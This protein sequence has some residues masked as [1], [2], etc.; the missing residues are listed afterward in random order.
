MSRKPNFINRSFKRQIFFLMLIVTLF[1]VIGGGIA[2][3]QGFQSRIRYDYQNQDEQQNESINEKLINA[4]KLSETTIEA[5]QNNETLIGAFSALGRDD[6]EI[7]TQLYDN[8]SLVRQFATV[9]LYANGRCIY[10]TNQSGNSEALP[11][12]YSILREAK[13]QDGKTVYSIDPNN[14]KDEGGTLLIARQVTNSYINGV[15]VIRITQG[16]ISNLLS[17]QI[18]SKD[19]FI[20]ANRYLRPFCQLGAAADGEFLEQI[21]SN[22]IANKLYT[23]GISSNVYMR[24]LDT[25]GLVCIYITPQPLE[26]SAIK[27][28]YHII[29]V[30]AV[31]SVVICFVLATGLSEYFSNP[32][33]K[34]NEAMKRFRKGDFD[35]KIEFDRVDEFQQLA[36]GFNKMTTQLKETMEERVAAERKTTQ[37]RIAMMQ[38]QLNP[39]FLYNTLDTIKWVAKANQVPEIATLSASLAG[40]LRNS[41]SEEQFCP[42]AKE[43]K[44]IENY[45]DIQRIRFEDRFSLIIDVEEELME[46]VIPKLILQ[47]LVE[48]A[49][50]HGFKELDEGQV[51]I[52][53]K[54]DGDNLLIFIED[55]GEGIS[56]EMINVLE[57]KDKASLKGHIG[58]N[59]VNT[60]IELYYGSEYGV[61]AQRRTEGGTRMTVCLPY[62]TE[63][64]NND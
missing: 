28:G 33:L 54:K 45:I 56:D 19:G 62:S 23:E 55:D 21:R 34:L 3:L 8:T 35:T 36:T 47:P 58:I 7:Y 13:E 61:K 60:I 63:D 26:D 17:G 51:V 59:N 15:V 18:N 6:Q 20:L 24:D 52:K 50:I 22:M 43:L 29:G 14:A 2:T 44:L 16:D 12:S 37:T 53:A 10:S 32:I 49:I 31:I 46:A 1:L 48:N 42:L 40:I 41:I 5:I 57:T 64:K 30:L 38:A 9:D 4:L 25:T 27:A 11:V 39:H